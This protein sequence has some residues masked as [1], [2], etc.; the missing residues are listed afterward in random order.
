[1][2]QNYMK[3]SR[4]TPYCFF[5]SSANRS[6]ILTIFSLPIICSGRPF[7][8][9]KE[10][11][12]LAYLAICSPNLFQRILSLLGRQRRKQSNTVRLSEEFMTPLKMD[13]LRQP[14]HSLRNGF[15]LPQVL[16]GSLNLQRRG[17]PLSQFNWWDKK[18]EEDYSQLENWRNASERIDNRWGILP[19]NRARQRLQDVASLG[20][21]LVRDKHQESG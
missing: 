5:V 13:L 14:I 1:M 17:T 18:G 9:I 3:V 2:P 20:T 21:S 7:L 19:R 16:L 15:L 11:V 12:L 8:S 4:Y 6:R 10:D